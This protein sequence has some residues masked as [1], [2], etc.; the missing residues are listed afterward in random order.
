MI[1]VLARG[2]ATGV[3]L[4]TLSRA[5]EEEARHAEICMRLAE[6]YARAPIPRL[7]VGDVPLP[8]FGVG[9]EE[10]ETTLLVAGMCCVN[11]TVAT[12][13]LSA[14]LK[15]SR[16]P[17]AITAN[18]LHLEEEIDHA[19]LGWAHLASSAVSDKTRDALGELLPA[20]L[21]SNAPGWERDDELLPAEGVSGHGHLSAGASRAVFREALRDLVIPGFAHVGV[22]TH[23]AS[24]W[25]SRR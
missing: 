13:W 11:E 24:T 15:D 16:A 10:L 20:L 7:E 2:G 17:L 1:P 23:R 12:A 25:L 5:T 8:R 4:Q 18:R 3:V 19:R 6:A 14:C 9:D 22:D 21:E